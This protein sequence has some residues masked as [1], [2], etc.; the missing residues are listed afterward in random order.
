MDARLQRTKEQRSAEQRTTY[1]DDC[2]RQDFVITARSLFFVD[3]LAQDRSHLA[4]CVGG[5]HAD[6]LQTRPNTE[7][8]S[9]ANGTAAAKAHQDICAGVDGILERLFRHVNGGVH[10]RVGEGS[11]RRD[12][13]M[14]EHGFKRLHPIALA[15][16]GQQQ[17]FHFAQSLHLLRKLLDTAAA[18]EDSTWL[19]MVFE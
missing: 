1:V 3:R 19:C 17:W 11:G 2:V 4:S 18:K 9:Q 6:V 10:G 8:L 12:G 14:L 13:R 7:S 5:G 16:S 15:R